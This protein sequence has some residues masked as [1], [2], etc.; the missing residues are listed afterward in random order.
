MSRPQGTLASPLV[1]QNDSASWGP[2]WWPRFKTPPS[3][4]CG[5]GSV[6]GWGARTPQATW[7]SQKVKNKQTCCSYTPSGIWIL[8]GRQLSVGVCPVHPS[9][10]SLRGLSE[11]NF[12]R[13]REPRSPS[14]NRGLLTWLWIQRAGGWFACFT[15]SSIILSCSS[16]LGLEH[17][18][19]PPTTETPGIKKSTLKGKANKLTTVN[20]IFKVQGKYKLLARMTKKKGEKI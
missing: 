5:A 13:D 1:H 11:L 17:I 3:T 8:D 10:G 7:H 2:P 16:S 20:A 6:P 12:V 19:N 14:L 18:E 9:L 4:A 15:A